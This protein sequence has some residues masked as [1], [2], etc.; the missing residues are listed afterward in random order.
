[1]AERIEDVVRRG[2]GE[3]FTV[4]FVGCLLRRKVH[5]RVRLSSIRFSSLVHSQ[6]CPDPRS[7]TATMPAR[8]GDCDEL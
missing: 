4:D 3:Q 2:C 8:V 1:M 6:S 5:Q 7:R